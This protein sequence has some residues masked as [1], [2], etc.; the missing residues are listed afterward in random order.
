MVFFTDNNNKKL[1]ALSNVAHAYLIGGME[2]KR[3]GTQHAS[4]VPY[5]SFKTKDGNIIIGAGN[6]GQFTKLC[7]ILQRPDLPRDSRYKTN[8][9]RVD[10]RKDLI[11]LIEDI[12]MTENTDTW[13]EKLRPSGIPSGPVNDMERTFNHPQVSHQS[14]FLYIRFR[15]ATT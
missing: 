9:D 15:H 11:A 5:Q 2:A 7:A 12:L 14:L 6:D 10:N 8:S 3:W 1:A 13:L 4:I